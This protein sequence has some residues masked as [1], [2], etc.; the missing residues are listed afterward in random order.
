MKLRAQR[1]KNWKKTINR[2][3]RLFGT[4]ASYGISTFKKVITIP[5]G[6]LGIK[7]VIKMLKIS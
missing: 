1:D 2:A 6:G 7:N 5:E 4:S 3:A